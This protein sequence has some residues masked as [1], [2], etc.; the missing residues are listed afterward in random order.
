MTRET[1]EAEHSQKLLTKCRNWQKR[2]ICHGLPIGDALETFRHLELDRHVDEKQLT[3]HR[4]VRTVG[5]DF[6]RRER[7]REQSTEVSFSAAENVFQNCLFNFTAMLNIK[8]TYN[9]ELID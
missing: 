9:L 4:A 3:R 6:C 7:R 1:R 2:G 5:V 8:Q